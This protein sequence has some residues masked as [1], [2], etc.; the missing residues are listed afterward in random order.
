MTEVCPVKLND[1]WRWN[2]RTMI[3]NTNGV[4]MINCSNLNNIHSVVLDDTII[5]FGWLTYLGIGFIFLSKC[6]D[7][8]PTFIYLIYCW[9]KHHRKVKLFCQHILVSSRCCFVKD[10]L[11]GLQ[12]LSHPP[13]LKQASFMQCYTPWQLRCQILLMVFGVFCAL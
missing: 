13:L 5:M 9:N 8:T 6:H 7:L 2:N 10:A 11:A 3:G 1:I 12:I 4:T